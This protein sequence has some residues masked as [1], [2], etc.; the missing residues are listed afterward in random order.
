MSSHPTTRQVFLFSLASLLILSMSTNFSFGQYRQ[1]SNWSRTSLFYQ[2]RD[3]RVVE[4]LGLSDDLKKKIRELEG[5][6]RLSAETYKSYT[7]RLRQAKNEVERTKIREELSAASDKTRKEAE[8]KA[9]KL[10]TDAQKT[11]LEQLKW[12]LNRARSRTILLDE[13]VKKLNI[14]DEQKTQI[15]KLLDQRSEAAI[16]RGLSRRSSK[17]EI[18]KFQAEWD[19]KTI[20]LLKPEQQKQWM[21]MIGPPL[22]ADLKLLS[23]K[24][25]KQPAPGISS[26]PGAKTPSSS[27][28]SAKDFTASFEPAGKQ[29]RKKSP[30]LYGAAKNNGNVAPGN[31][32]ENEQPM[33]FTFVNAP[34]KF[35]LEF[36]AKKTGLSLDMSESPP[37]TFTYR[38]P[39]LYTPTQV[40]DVLNGYLLQKNFILV[41]RNRAL[42]VHNLA[43]PIPPSIIPDVQPEELDSRG[44]NELMRV[45]FAIKDGVDAVDVAKEVEEINDASYSKV[46]TFASA[47]RIV[48]TDIGT[49]LIRINKIL[50]DVTE[51]V[52]KGDLAFRSFELKYIAANE[53]EKLVSQQLG[54][55]SGVTNV[56]AAS[57]NSGNPFSRSRSSSSDRRAQFMQMMMARRS[58]RFG[59]PSSSSSSSSSSSRRSSGAQGDAKVTAN[60]RTNSLLVT[61][62]LAKIKIVEKLIEAIDVKV[63]GD[64]PLVQ[65]AQNN[66]PYLKVYRVYRSDVQEV[67]KTLNVLVPDVVVN[68]DARNDNIHIMATSEEH[69]YV[70]ELLKELDG[71]G[72]GGQTLDA[73]RLRRLDPVAVANTLTAM[74]ADERNA[75][76]SIQ[77]DAQG[78]QLLV[79]G[80][81]A[82]ISQIKSFVDKLEGKG[83]GAYTSNGQGGN[84]RVLQ[85]PG[86]S[87]QFLRTLQQ[88]WSGAN[89]DVPIRIVV[90]SDPDPIQNRLTPNNG[91]SDLRNRTPS[92]GFQPPEESQENRSNTGF[93]V[94]PKSPG[95]NRRSSNLVLTGG[96]SSQFSLPAP[97]TTKSEP[98]SSTNAKPQPKNS[99]SPVATQQKPPAS[100]KQAKGAGVSIMVQDGQL[101]I[102]SNDTAALNRMQTLIE[103]LAQAI[104]VK[105]SWTVFYLRVADATEAASMLEQIFPTSSVSSTTSASGGGLMGSLTGGL[106]SFGNSLMNISGLNSLGQSPDSLR[107][108]PD[109]RSNSLF[110]S[111]SQS[112]IRDVERVLKILDEDK[113]PESLRDRTPRMIP[114]NYA[115]VNDVYQSVADL[116]KDYMQPANNGR[117]GANALALLMGG[118]RR[119][120]RGAQQRPQQVRLTLSV[121]ERT[122]QLLVSASESLFRQ[123]EQFVYQL[124][125]S[126]YEAKRTTRVVQL[127]N[128]S[129]SVITQTLTSMYPNVSVSVSGGGTRRTSSGNT[130]NSQTNPSQSDQFRNAMRAQFLQRMMQGQNNGRSNIQP[131]SGSFRGGRRSGS[132]GFSPFGRGSRGSSG[133]N[134]FS[135]GGSSRGGFNPFGGGRR[136]R[137]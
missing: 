6:S 127:E 128:A 118:N 54:I 132:S 62:P 49:N 9:L 121:D 64:N 45:T 125:K 133:F 129:S 12:R 111:G 17:E 136:G 84:I 98:S 40:L 93:R 37:D 47:N 68:E 19:P 32:R 86:D 75:A 100:E 106:N 102:S 89:P 4:E 81:S 67:T 52:E 2:L 71:G 112:K 105:T 1:R 57:G 26:S 7:D 110:V 70:T 117:G 60:P 38:D 55:S 109:I 96:N 99:T 33:S 126:A 97:E 3:N 124:D 88:M 120:S 36:F 20:A 83:A 79:K 35:V 61:A 91:G 44:R 65:N 113:L 30:V 58:G 78:R 131:G 137:R 122:G 107:I 11:R 130:P 66:G 50:K 95:R 16:K 10:L 21:A 29:A 103:S 15:N 43:N 63:D 5:Q 74:F 14:T 76:P 101:V 135:G 28:S 94:P 119:G 104:P 13:V 114:V 73:I 46:I 123:I 108:I 116:Y 134:P 72:S 39:N 59:T 18:A 27:S 69:Q 24:N 87:T 48:V 92:R 8:D 34:W 51:K 77:A 41:R 53:A 42:V 80:S 25:T 82:Q 85:V 31:K 56:S 23:A 115:D 90:P 22:K